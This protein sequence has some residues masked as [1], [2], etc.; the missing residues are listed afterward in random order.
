VAIFGTYDSTLDLLKAK[1][2]FIQNKPVDRIAGV[3]TDINRDDFTLTIRTVEER[4]I[5]I[6]IET[7]SRTVRWDGT[8]IVKSGFSK[9][10]MDDTLHIQGTV[11]P[12]KENR[13]SAIRILDLGNLSGTVPT[14]TATPTT[15]TT[16][17]GT[18]APSPT[19]K[20]K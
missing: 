2:I 13:Y 5:V 19:S 8:S 1:F 15:E 9:I 7:T 10:A 6:D 18:L 14:A 20:A 11:V 4:S 12:K 16:P 17:E 3:V